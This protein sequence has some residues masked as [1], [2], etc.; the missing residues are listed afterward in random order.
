M[1]FTSN[2][3]DD[4][5][6]MIE[7]LDSINFY[8][9]RKIKKDRV[10]DIPNNDG[11]SMF[12]GWGSII[13]NYTDIYRTRPDLKEVFREFANIYFP[14]FKYTGVQ[15]NKNY[16]IT[17]HFDKNNVGYSILCTFGDYKYGETVIYNDET[18]EI[19]DFDA[20]KKPLLFN[21]SK[22][23]H[24]GNSTKNN[25]TRYC[26]VFINN[27]MNVNKNLV[28]TDILNNKNIEIFAPESKN[29]SFS[30]SFSKNYNFLILFIIIITSIVLYIIN[31]I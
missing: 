5:N 7:I 13:N 11:G 26:L 16:P 29:Y 17:P 19:L 24:W 28:N 31:Y 9:Y 3:D 2:W 23:L 1:I 15:I 8:N 12:Y 30:D 25:E 22:Y 14:E 4:K 20:R 6:R 27:K 21:G 18:R 10:L